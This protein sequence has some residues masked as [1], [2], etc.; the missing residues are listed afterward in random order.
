MVDETNSRLNRRKIL[1]MS[2]VGLTGIAGNAA[3]GTA[4]AGSPVDKPV[5][6]DGYE[7][8]RADQSQQNKPEFTENGKVGYAKGGFGKPITKGTIDKLYSHVFGN[9]LDRERI[10]LPRPIMN[11]DGPGRANNAMGIIVSAN[12]DTPYIS[13][14]REPSGFKSPS[15]KKRK[16]VEG[17]IHARIDQKVQKQRNVDKGGR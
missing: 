1:Q 7:E 8:S 3:L 10:A 16:Q 2:G 14:E 5:L 15:A 6:H 17:M 12:A 4:A 11:D 9:N 13:V